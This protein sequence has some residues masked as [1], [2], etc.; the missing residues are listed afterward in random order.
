MIIIKM[1]NN[2]KYT[3]RFLSSYNTVIIQIIMFYNN[4]RDYEYMLETTAIVK[5]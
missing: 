1:E 5:T 2:I 4:E 3:L